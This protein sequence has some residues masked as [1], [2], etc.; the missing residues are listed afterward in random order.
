MPNQSK[1]IRI[2][3]KKWGLT[4]EDLAKAIHASKS[5][6]AMYESGART[7]DIK[8]LQDIASCFSVSADELISGDFSDSQS[9]FNAPTNEKLYFFID[10][11]FPYV[12]SNAAL[13][14]QYFATAYNHTI[15]FLDSAKQRNVPVLASHLSIALNNYGLSVKE[16]STI[17]SVA[18]MLWIIVVQY[19][20]I[21]D[22]HIAQAGEAFLNGK[23]KD[24]DFLKK[25]VFRDKDS[26]DSQSIENKRTY[27]K[28]HHDTVYE[29]IKLLKRS[30]S[31][32]ELGD[33]YL[34]LIYILNMV[35]NDH[36]AEMNQT[37]GMEMMN[38]LL[39]LDNNYAFNFLD[40]I[41]NLYELHES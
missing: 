29:L 34:A 6:I 32:S 38:S 18:N 15:T 3:R 24:K 36:T 8:T 16:F 7:P 25:Y 21:Y 37:I 19:V 22:K 27:A 33:Y 26:I 9:K 10:R 31:Y 23:C 17:E 14:D 41:F 13:K 1:N 30:E 20:L 39:Q 5:S 2:L 11:C 40:G 28:K 12:S 4:Q 35:D